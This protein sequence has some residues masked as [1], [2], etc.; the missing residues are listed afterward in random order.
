MV[1]MAT[2]KA[3]ISEL[4]CLTYLTDFFTKLNISPR[5]LNLENSSKIQTFEFPSDAR[6][7]QSASLKIQKR[8]DKRQAGLL[9]F[10]LYLFR[11]GFFEI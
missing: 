2:V 11:S 10:V 6:C 4:N 9:A 8:Y 7:L 1:A 5:A 3:W